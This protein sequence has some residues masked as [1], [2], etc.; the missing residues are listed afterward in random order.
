MSQKGAIHFDEATIVNL[1]VCTP[2]GPQGQRTAAVGSHLDLAPTLLEFAGLSEEET[3]E[4][5]SHL[6]GRSLRGVMLDPRREGP[7]GSPNAPGDGALLCWDGLNSL[8]KDRAISGALKELSVMNLAPSALAVDKKAQM[9]EAGKKYGAPDFSKR[10][11]L[12]AIVDG[13]YKLVRW[14]SREEYGNPDTIEGLYAQGNVTLQDLV[15][16][17]GE[18]ENLAHREHP[19][20]DP[21]NVERMLP[22][23][24][25]LVRDQIG[26]ERAPFDL[27][28]FG[29]RELKYHTGE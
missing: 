6:K 29:T 25:A 17:P 19:D 24:R 27:D 16:G 4:R 2:G 5:Y 20:H 3:C 22:K 26:E 14:F 8:D 11:F 7:C 18:L 1:T 10:N 23:L 28:M 9:K 13:R 12:R 15:G 21:A